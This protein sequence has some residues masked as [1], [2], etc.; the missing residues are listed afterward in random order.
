MWEEEVLCSCVSLLWEDTFKEEVS[1]TTEEL[2]K[3][4]D[5]VLEEIRRVSYEMID[6][7]KIASTPLQHVG[8]I[9]AGMLQ[10]EKIN[11]IMDTVMEQATFRS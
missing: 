5:S 2:K 10:A 1:M 11:Q 3:T 9:L 4:L 6:Q 8:M 7:G